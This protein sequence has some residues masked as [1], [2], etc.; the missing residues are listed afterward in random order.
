LTPSERDKAVQKGATAVEHWLKRFD[1]MVVGPGLGRDP[2]IH[3][4]VKQ[5]M[6]CPMTMCKMLWYV[7]GLCRDPLIHD[8]V[9]QVSVIVTSIDASVYL[10]V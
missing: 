8:T 6:P 10:P 5:V 2:L 4:T 1:V 3:D 9:K 7:S